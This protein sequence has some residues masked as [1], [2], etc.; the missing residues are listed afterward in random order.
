MHAEAIVQVSGNSEDGVAVS[1]YE[2]TKKAPSL[3]RRG[4]R[5][6]NSRCRLYSRLGLIKKEAEFFPA[7]G[8]PE[9]V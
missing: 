3:K 1:S 5:Q 7:A 4:N 8:M 2:K 6:Y 9:P